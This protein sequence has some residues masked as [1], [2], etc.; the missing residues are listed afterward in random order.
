MGHLVILFAG[1]ERLEFAFEDLDEATTFLEMAYKAASECDTN[2][3]VVL[4]MMKNDYN[5]KEK[6]VF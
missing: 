5:D 4:C 2:G 1:K 3:K 6:W